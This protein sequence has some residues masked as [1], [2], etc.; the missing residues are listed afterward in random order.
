MLRLLCRR[1]KTCMQTA[2]APG[3]PEQATSPVGLSLIVK[4]DMNF[5]AWL[6]EFISEVFPSLKWDEYTLLSADG[7][8]MKEA[9]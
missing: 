6:K 2:V 4:C 8:P 7:M 1:E 3:D 5:G 9:K